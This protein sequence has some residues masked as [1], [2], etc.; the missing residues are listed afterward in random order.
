MKHYIYKT[1]SFFFGLALF[2]SGQA[3]SIGGSDVTVTGAA[4]LNTITTAVPF[5]MI[6]PDTR[7]SAMGDAGVATSPDANSIHWNNAKT[8]FASEDFELS[9]SYTPWLRKLVSDI[10]LSY[11]SFYK[12]IDKRSAVSGSLRYFT[13]GDIQFTNSFGQN[14]I[15]FRPNEFSIDAGYSMQLSERFA[16]GTAIRFVNSNLTGGIN[17]QGTTTKPGRAIGVDLS[18]YYVN[19]DVEFSGKD[20]ELALGF[21]ITNI[22]NK[23]SYSETAK[24]DFIPINLRLGPRYTVNFDEF[25]QLSLTLDINK[26]LV[27]TPPVYAVDSNGVTLFDDDGSPVILTGTDPNK[28]VVS[29]MFGSFSDAPGIVLRNED[30]DILYND[31][32]SVRIDKG[33]R[34]SEELREFTLGFGAEYWYNQQFAV[35]GGYFWE[36]RLKG[37]R[38]YF[39]LGAGVRYN[40]FSLDFS[41]LIPAYFGGNVQRSP[42]ENTIRFTLGFN[43]GKLGKN[44]KSTPAVDGTSN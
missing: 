2:M 7:A 21:A 26:L 22:G 13:L 3:Q 36:H 20:A 8:A 16:F 44:T 24:R 14:T 30:G 9:L 17:V 4:S 40:V 5:L 28:P 39:T 18:G 27:P 25:N 1:F 29:G 42:L 10:S 11:L 15:Q 6:S 35:R 32:G 41:Y 12:K 31:D 43:F 19:D 38:K 33:S 37:N 34:F 23:M